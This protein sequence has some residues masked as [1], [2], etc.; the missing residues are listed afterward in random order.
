MGKKSLPGESEAEDYLSFLVETDY[1]KDTSVVT[2]RNVDTGA[3]LQKFEH[4]NP[5]INSCLSENGKTLIYVASDLKSSTMIVRD[6]DTE[7]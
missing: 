4:D 6:V 7:A 1:D 5:V 2:V 3:Q